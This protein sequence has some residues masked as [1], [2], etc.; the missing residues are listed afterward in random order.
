[1]RH[2]EDKTYFQTW[3][4]LAVIL[5]IVFIVLGLVARMVYLTVIDRAFLTKQGQSRSLRV[6]DTP[7]YRGMILDT[8]QHPLAVSTPVDSVWMNPQDFVVTPASIQ[9]VANLLDIHPENLLALIQKNQHKHFV[10]VKRGVPPAVASDLLSLNIPG[11]YL[12]HMYR[13][14]Y[15][16]GESLAQV[17]GNTNIDN[18]GQSGLEL[19]YNALLEGVP[20]QTLVEQDRHG[21]TVSILKEVQAERPGTNLVLSIDQRIQ[22][23]TYQSLVDALIEN[24]ASSGTAVVV[25]TRTGEIL[26]MASA[27]SYNPNIRIAHEDARYRNRVVTDVFEPGSMMKTFAILNALESGRYT[28]DTKIDTHPGWMRVGRN[29]VRDDDGKDHGVLSLTGVLQV[30]S[31][32]GIAKVTLE[33]TPQRLW[34]VLHKVG[35]GQLT[36]VHFPGE[37]TGSLVNHKRW[38][39]ITAATLSFGYGMS[40]TPL[41]LAR[42]YTVFANQGRLIPLTFLKQQNT[43][44]GEQVLNPKTVQETV[45]ILQTVLTR[46]GTGY[47]ARVPGY[48][49]AGKTGTARMLIKGKYSHKNHIASFVGFGPVS[50]PQLVVLVVIE[51]PQGKQYYASYV[52]APAFSNIMSNAL[53][54]L[55]VPPD[56]E[57]SLNEKVSAKKWVA[58]I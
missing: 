4:F 44:Q 33:L 29:I 7:A 48:T 51:N 54:L 15:P 21:H 27:P 32:V 20:G 46:D 23:L 24:K 31:N 49:I 14:Y 50:N 10:Y 8:N 42:A 22:D 53:R 47:L 40:A 57:A 55:N 1:M 6:I 16:D 52:A 26:A 18:I 3:R 43:L 5:V 30:S 38:A 39:Q 37:R 56:D 9:Q 11:I 34:N 12:Q 28:P 41:Q 17:L 13:R 2:D 58:P 19:T 25:N 36:G 45:S 35:F